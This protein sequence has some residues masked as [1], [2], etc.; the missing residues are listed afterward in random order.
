MNSVE[1]RQRRLARHYLNHDE[2]TARVAA[3]V[4]LAAKSL[5]F[6]FAQLNILD[7][8]YQYTVAEVG[9]GLCPPVPRTVSMCQFVLTDGPL[10]I[11]DLR[12]DNRFNALPG[13]RDGQAASYL[14]VPLAS[15]ESTVVGT[16]CVFDVAPRHITATQMERI[17][18]FADI[19]EDQLDIL[20]RSSEGQRHAPIESAALVRAIDED[21]IVPW[22]QPIVELATGTTVG[23]EALA[24]WEH[25][26]GETEDPS[27]FVPLAEDS[28]LVIEMDRAVMR[29]ALEDARRWR[30][31]R[32][33]TMLNLNLSTRH[34]ELADGISTIHAAVVAAG[35]TPD[36]VRFELTETRALSDEEQAC[37][38][39]LQL[40][41]LGYRVVLDDF[42][43]GWSSLDWLLR[44]PVTGIKIDRVV[45]AAL[46]SHAGDAVIR[47]ITGLAAE[48]GVKTVIEGVAT[49]RHVE[50]ARQLGCG[51]GQGYF[52]SPPVPAA[53]IDVT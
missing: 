16:L 43:T 27:R 6:P 12:A 8:E 41:E 24:R 39:V 2:S 23:Y 9:L 13:V 4:A 25:P 5:N 48:L 31:T 38:A 35:V 42:G 36:A 29:R 28:D 50:V 44:L 32:P 40:R 33:S 49:A 20:R 15:R 19:V 34:L 47:A 1:Q 37:A 21:E 10:A 30:E 53:K 18:K 22:Y 14:G 52:W 45:T 51:Y 26:T 3:T 46:G 11:N 7:D 17:R